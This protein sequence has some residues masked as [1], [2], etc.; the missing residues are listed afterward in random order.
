MMLLVTSAGATWREA[1]YRSWLAEAGFDRVTV[2]PTQTAAGVIFA[3]SAG[4]GRCEWP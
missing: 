4:G 3:R 2:E 1:D